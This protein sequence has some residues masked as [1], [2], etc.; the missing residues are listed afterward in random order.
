MTARQTLPKTRLSRNASL[1]L[2]LALCPGLPAAEKLKA[3]IV[4]GQNN[5]EVWPKSTIMM[6]HYLEET[7]LFAVDVVRTRFIWKSEREA[8]YLRWPAPGSPKS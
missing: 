2:L 3:L 4:D 6:K 7:G 5:H 8:G 1:F